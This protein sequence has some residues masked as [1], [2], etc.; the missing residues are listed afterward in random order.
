M[1]DELCSTLEQLGAQHKDQLSDPDLTT[2]AV[3]W[4]SNLHSVDLSFSMCQIRR[5]AQ[6][7]DRGS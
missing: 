2:I 4:K 1:S 3:T 5:Q 7:V 6:R